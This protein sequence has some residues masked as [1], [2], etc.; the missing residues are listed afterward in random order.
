MTWKRPTIDAMCDM[1]RFSAWA[2]LI[3]NGILG[4]I[5]SVYFVARLLWHSR[6]WCDRVLFSHAW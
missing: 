3:F 4:S 1:L 2:C 6:G 5:F